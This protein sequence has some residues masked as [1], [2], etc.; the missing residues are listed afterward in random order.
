MSWKNGQMAMLKQFLC[1]SLLT[2]IPMAA[3]VTA[4]A[5]AAESVAVPV[6]GNAPVPVSNDRRAFVEHPNVAA[7]LKK[8]V[9][10]AAVGEP[11]VRAIGPILY[12]DNKL[13]PNESDLILELL[14]NKAGKV[15]I[16]TAGGDSF[17]VPVLTQAA[18]DFLALHD[19]PDLNTLWLKGPKE[20]K[21]LVD[22]TVLNPNVTPQVE[23]F[24]GQNLF[25]SW[26][27]SIAMK[28]NRYLRETL[29]AAVN[30]FRLSGPE[31]ERLGRRLLYR[32]ML[33]VDAANKNAIPNDLYLYLRATTPPS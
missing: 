12:A 19:P 33:V 11:V 27:A 5:A 31:T 21:M 25:V 9:D 24:F 8:A 13:T 2:L 32:A 7:A 3:S 26:R 6:M 4:A 28:N 20:M 14:G 18:H 16:T 29:N 10:A 30:Q 22:V 23:Q 15:T 17:A 1:A